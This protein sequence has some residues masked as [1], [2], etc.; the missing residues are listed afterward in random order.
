MSASTSSISWPKLAIAKRIISTS[1]ICAIAENVGGS[2][3]SCWIALKI[4]PFPSKQ[5]F[6]TTYPAPRTANA[7]HL[8]PPIAT[9]RFRGG[10]PARSTL[11][12]M[13]SSSSANTNVAWEPSVSRTMAVL[14]ITPSAP[15]ACAFVRTTTLRRTISVCVASVP[16][17]RWR[18]TAYLRTP[19]AR[20]RT[21][22]ISRAP[23]SAERDTCT[24]R[25]SA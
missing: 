1:G 24:L 17:A 18:M 9:R 23:A 20:R 16:T 19:N 4:Y 15:I 10:A 5:P 14:W 7:V 12:T 13:P 8:A 3:A 6:N 21:R 11:S 2:N 25:M 22:R